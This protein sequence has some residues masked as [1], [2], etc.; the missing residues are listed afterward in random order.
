MRKPRVEATLGFQ[1]AHAFGVESNHESL[2]LFAFSLTAALALGLTATFRLFSLRLCRSWL[3]HRLRRSW[4]SHAFSLWLLLRLSYRTFTLCGLSLFLTA[5][6]R[7][8]LLNRRR[9]SYRSV[10]LRRLPFLLTAIRGRLYR[11]INLHSL[12]LLL[13]AT[14]RLLLLARS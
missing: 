13:T 10:S 11:S 1:F 14:Y 12:L 9:L 3:G 7:P 4:L 5:I 2:R 8:L 6:R